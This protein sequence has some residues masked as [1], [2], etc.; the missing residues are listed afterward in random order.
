MNTST[1]VLAAAP[2]ATVKGESLWLKARKR[3][4]R[5]K[6]A[7]AGLVAVAPER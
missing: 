4:L 5:H 2:E 7:M 1:L 6:L 3:F